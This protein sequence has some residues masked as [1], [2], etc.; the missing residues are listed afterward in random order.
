M[1]SPQIQVFVG[2]ENDVLAIFLF[3]FKWIPG[4]S[5]GGLVDFSSKMRRGDDKETFEAGSQISMSGGKSLK[6]SVK[7]PHNAI[8]L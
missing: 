5:S 3:S 8:L 1:P 7:G 6:M 4:A 2:Y